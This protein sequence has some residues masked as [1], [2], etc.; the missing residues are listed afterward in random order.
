MN[1]EFREAYRELLRRARIC[2]RAVVGPAAR[3]P[4]RSTLSAVPPMYTTTA[5]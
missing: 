2:S 5:H 1:S 4:G 3:R